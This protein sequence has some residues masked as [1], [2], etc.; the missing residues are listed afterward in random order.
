MLDPEQQINPPPSSRAVR[1]L[2]E[3]SE[4]DQP[5]SLTING[6]ITLPVRDQASLEKLLDLVEWLDTVE[7]LRERLDDVSGGEVCSLEEV[8]ARLQE[9]HGIPR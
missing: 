6:K 4:S 1:S 2:L 3:L 5:I 9:K 8:R 7:L